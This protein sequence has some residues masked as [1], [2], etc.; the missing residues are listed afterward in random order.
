ML[1]NKKK[2]IDG[3]GDIS[4][5][6]PVGFSVSIGD[7]LEI[8]HSPACREEEKKPPDDDGAR[9]DIEA[10]LKSVS[11]AI[12]HRESAGRSGRIVTVLELRPAP[13]KKTSEALAKAIRKGLGCGSRVEADKVFLQGDIRDRAEV[14]LFKRGV[15]KIVMGN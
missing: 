12:I 14:W 3:Q 13:D 2:K 1:K 6:C 4:R 5:G 8:P 15:R 9:Q 7:I 11:R 10:F